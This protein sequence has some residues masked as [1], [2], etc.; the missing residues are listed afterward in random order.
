[1][2][3]QLTRRMRRILPTKNN[4][5]RSQRPEP[6]YQL[7]VTI[8]GSPG[9][10]AGSHRDEGPIRVEGVIQEFRFVS[11]ED[12]VI[13]LFPIFASTLV[14]EVL[15]P[16]LIRIFDSAKQ[17]QKLPNNART[18]DEILA[19]LQNMSCFPARTARYLHTG[20]S[21]HGSQTIFP[22]FL[23]W[24]S[25]GRHRQPICC[26]ARW[27]LFAVGPFCSGSSVLQSSVSFPSMN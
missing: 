5:S 24:S 10:T 11:T 12:G 18:F 14:S 9:K 15:A 27:R 2:R 4:L 1:M 20:R 17:C 22:S 8:G 6:D 26:S 19:L 25:A 23:A 13:D 16:N 21:L 3:I 7:G